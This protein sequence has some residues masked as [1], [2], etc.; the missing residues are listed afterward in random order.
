M[1]TRGQARKQSVAQECKGPG[2]DDTEL[3]VS[4]SS[5][6]PC[7]S[8][9]GDVNGG[10]NSA[11]GGRVDRSD[12]PGSS[13]ASRGFSVGPRFPDSNWV[14]RWSLDEL[15]NFQCQDKHKSEVLKLK[16]AG[17]EKPQKAELNGQSELFKCLCAQWSVLK[18]DGGLLV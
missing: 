5:S 14:D 8:T 2:D 12:N 7:E 11:S 13:I 17:G 15:K 10:S 3:D 4:D 6:V 16:S 1:V 9:K 18:I